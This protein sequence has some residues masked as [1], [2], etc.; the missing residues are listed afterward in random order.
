MRT[1]EDVVIDRKDEMVEVKGTKVG[2]RVISTD[3]DTLFLLQGALR[4][5]WHFGGPENAAAFTGRDI[6]RIGR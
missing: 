6:A 1:V 4:Y 5:Q 2:D 3:R